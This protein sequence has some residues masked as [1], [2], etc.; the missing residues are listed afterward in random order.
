MKVITRDTAEVEAKT[1]VV[2]KDEAEANKEAEKE[3]AKLEQLE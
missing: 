3:Y 1:I 2:R